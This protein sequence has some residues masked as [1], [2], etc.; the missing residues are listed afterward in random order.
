MLF[1]RISCVDFS[2]PGT[3]DSACRAV[4]GLDLEYVDV[5]VRRRFPLTDPDDVLRDPR[6]V[7]AARRG[8]LKR[9]QLEAAD[10]FCLS[11]EPIPPNRDDDVFREHERAVFESVCLLA[12]EIGAP[13]V[14]VLPGSCEG[15]EKRQDAWDRSVA[16]LRWRVDRAE[17]HQ[18]ILSVE[19]HVGSVVDTPARV[20]ALLDEV[21]GL[22]L[23]LDYSHFVYQGISPTDVHP[24]L[25]HARVVHVRQAAGG[26]IQTAVGSG[27]IDFL[28]IV[29][30]A[31]A[32]GFG[33]TYTL[34]YVTKPVLPSEAVD[35]VVESKKMRDVVSAALSIWSDLRGPVHG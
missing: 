10:V 9:H 32:N 35:V 6:D 13:G 2:F 33:G 34:E 22:R 25:A 23:T 12:R 17:A 8:S 18:L 16:E 24:L 11:G 4:R 7:A 15:G 3:F 14:T 20:S 31:R 28:D 21:P 29:N 26:L 19:P 27:S 1:T 30:A 5:S